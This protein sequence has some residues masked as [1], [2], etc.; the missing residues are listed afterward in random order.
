[1]HMIEPTEY[2]REAINE[3]IEPFICGEGRTT[4]SERV[5]I[6]KQLAALVAAAREEGR[7]EERERCARIAENED[8]EDPIG[9]ASKYVVSLPAGLRT[10]GTKEGTS[11]TAAAKFIAAKIRIGE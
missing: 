10:W 4:F 7:A 8:D 11:S 6:R 5:E 2:D 1:L 3:I 9:A